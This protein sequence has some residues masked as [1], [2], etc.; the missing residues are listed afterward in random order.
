TNGYIAKLDSLGNPIWVRTH[1]MYSINTSNSPLLFITNIKTITDNKILA[2]GYLRGSGVGISTVL[3]LSPSDSIV[4]SNLTNLDYT[5]FY[6]IYDSL[7][8]IFKHGKVCQ[9]RIG[10]ITSPG[11][12]DIDSKKNIYINAYVTVGTF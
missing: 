2:Y 9:G 11:Q 8:N 3:K 10:F 5:G 7:G 6:I 4:S 1:Y 12:L